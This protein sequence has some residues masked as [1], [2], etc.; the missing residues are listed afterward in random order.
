MQEHAMTDK[1]F[2]G[3][4]VS[5]DD[6]AAAFHGSRKAEHIANNREAILAWLKEQDLAAIKIAAFEP[7][8]GYEW[9]LRR[10]LIEAGVFFVRVHPVE[11]VAYRTR[12][13]I[14]A[15]TDDLDAILIAGFAAEELDGRGLLPM[16]EG[17]DS[18]RELAV[19]RRQLAAMR[20]AEKC[21]LNM[22]REAPAIASITR[23]IQ[24]LDDS[25]EAIGNELEA[26]IAAD[27]ELGRM[28]A[29]L[30][31]LKG[32]GPV[33][34]QTLLAELPEL[35]RLDNKEIASLV[36]L[37]PKTR[38][39]GKQT[40]KARIG[41]GRPGVRHVLF[42]AARCAIRHNHIMKDFFDRLVKTNRRPGKIALT[43]VMRKMLVTL[44][45][46]ARERKPWKHQIT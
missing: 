15:K 31:S 7:T 41:H 2:I 19:R 35:G 10:A 29:N 4:D 39:S 11:V 5:K 23:I 24:A 26:A 42:N 40:F 16:V 27:A 36:G 43:A 46:I 30:K 37:A 13:A 14:K 44:N 21:R 12:R 34:V 45:A 22:A 25:L 1:R 17:N 32:I 9:E 18:L 6:I 28:A 3:F 8:G 33:S 38:K 20:H